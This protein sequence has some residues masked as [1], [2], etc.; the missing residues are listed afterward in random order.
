MVITNKG[1]S[2]LV[3][4]R[5]LR[6]SWF[7]LLKDCCLYSQEMRRGQHYHIGMYSKT[8]AYRRRLKGVI[9]YS[10]GL[11]WGCHCH[12]ILLLLLFFIFYS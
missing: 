8:L 11:R 1:L 2:V 4:A 12:N 9:V 7:L 10:Q 6:I 3:A 5:A